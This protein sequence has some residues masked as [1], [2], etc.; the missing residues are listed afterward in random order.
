[1]VDVGH[2]HPGA[3]DVAVA[4][5]G[6]LEGAADIAQ[7]LHRL[8]VG[9]AGPDDLAAHVSRGGAGDVD[10]STDSNRT[11]ITDDGLPRRAA[12]DVLPRHLPSKPGAGGGATFHVTCDGAPVERASAM[13]SSVARM[14]SSTAR[15]GLRNVTPPI[16]AVTARPS[17]TRMS[18]SPARS[19]SSTMRADAAL[20]SGRSAMN[21]S[22]PNRATTSVARSAPRNAAAADRT[23]SSPTRD[24]RSIAATLKGC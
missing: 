12:G 4:G 11:G 6:L 8:G 16:A 19:L 3:H 5:S 2:I 1:M 23:R 21:S 10:D 14:I 17:P 24:P 9:I 15:G 22:R 13:R 18:A 7:R 20:V